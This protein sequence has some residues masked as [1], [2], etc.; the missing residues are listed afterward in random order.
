MYS[1]SFVFIQYAGLLLQSHTYGAAK[2]TR[3]RRP[4]E[5]L[6]A[7]YVFFSFLFKQQ[8]E[9]IRKHRKEHEKK[10]KERKT[11]KK[12]EEEAVLAVFWRRLTRKKTSKLRKKKKTK[13]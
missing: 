9:S 12:K 13:Q 10:R 3:N 4:L 8:H 6:S 11:V 5:G 7:L 1:G 2:V